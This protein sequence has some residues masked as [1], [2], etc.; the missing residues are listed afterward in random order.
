V[1]WLKEANHY[2]TNKQNVQ[3]VVEK[4]TDA[5]TEVELLLLFTIA[6]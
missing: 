4:D 6:K 5:N 3:I 2:S 1:Q